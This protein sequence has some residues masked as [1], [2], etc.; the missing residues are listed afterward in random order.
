MNDLHEFYTP[1]LK[2]YARI[3]G[4]ICFGLAMGYRAGII[5]K[6]EFR[7]FLANEKEEVVVWL[8]TGGCAQDGIELITP[9]SCREKRE[10]NQGKYVFIFFHR[11]LNK[12][13]R[14]VA[15]PKVMEVYRP[16][17][18]LKAKIRN[19]TAS[20]EE[21]VRF[22]KISEREVERILKLPDSDLFTIKRF[23]MALLVKLNPFEGVYV[24]ESPELD[25]I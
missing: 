7:G 17:S 20:Q 12:A 14:L 21:I 6:E 9:C 13:I 4:H 19:N 10:E 15:Q 2:E 8:E 3:H 22:W 11:V 16:I 5:A 24:P 23:D 1:E 25:N 18:V